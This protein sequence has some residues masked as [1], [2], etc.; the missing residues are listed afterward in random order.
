[1][2]PTWLYV[3]VVYALAIWLARS[4]GV[5]VPAARRRILLLARS[6]LHV[7]AADRRLGQ[8]PDRHHPHA[9]ALVADQAREA[10]AQRPDERHRAADRAV[11][12]SVARGAEVVLAAALE[13]DD[14]L[15]LSAAGQ[16]SARTVLD[17]PAARAAAPAGVGDHRRGGVQSAR[18]DD[19]HVSARASQDVRRAPERDR[20]GSASASARSCT[21]GCISRS[22]PRQRS[23][24][25]RSIRSICSRSGSRTGASSSPRCCGR[26][27]STTGIPKRSRTPRF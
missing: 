27:C 7:E 23:S 17:R 9:A 4:G 26:P 19:V 15:R 14:R 18:G 8:H 25:L 21:S 13:L 16:R 2:N 3:G 22:A 10:F 12:A 11:G 6:D 20:R 1:M 5:V 24:P